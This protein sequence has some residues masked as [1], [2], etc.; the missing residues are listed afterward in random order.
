M[1]VVSPATTWL[2][3]KCTVSLTTIVVEHMQLPPRRPLPSQASPN[4]PNRQKLPLRV[5]NNQRREEGG[6][7][8]VKGNTNHPRSELD[9]AQLSSILAVP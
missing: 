8:E 9:S 2:E 5:P 7:G 3:F 4:Q 6:G 1:H